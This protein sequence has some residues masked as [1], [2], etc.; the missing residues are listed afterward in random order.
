MARSID[1]L[2]LCYRVIAGPDG[3]DMDLPPVPVEGMEPAHDP[4]IAWAASLPGVPVSMEMRAAVIGLAAKLEQAG[5]RLGKSLP[6]VDFKELAQT[7]VI[8]SRAVRVTFRDDTDEEPPTL[9]EYMRALDVRDRIT[10]A[11]EEYF[12]E[13]DA[14]ICPVSMTTAFPH[15]PDDEPIDVDGEAVNYWRAIGHCAP[16]NFTGHP[17]VAVPISWDKA[18]LPIG[19]QVVGKRW[20]EAKLLGVAR[21]VA[22]VANFTL[23]VP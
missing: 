10:R 17:S 5:L 2:S 21:A 3:K 22:E 4:K 15:S 20:S 19:V 9:V 6:R 12:T 11:W 16:F 7:R 18:G 14:L 1:D 8:I 23:P 13:W